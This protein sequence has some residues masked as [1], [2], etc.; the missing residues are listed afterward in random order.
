MEYG[1]QEGTCLLKKISRRIK[2]G[3]GV[4]SFSRLAAPTANGHD[5]PAAPQLHDERKGVI[6][7][8]SK[9]E[10]RAGGGEKARKG[11]EVR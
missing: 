5:L 11:R 4:G 8:I 3:K 6:V 2:K 9:R 1:R 7:N 10:G